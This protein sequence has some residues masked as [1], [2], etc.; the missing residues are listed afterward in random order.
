M[1]L[2]IPLDRTT[3]YVVFGIIIIG[4]LVID[5]GILNRDAKKVS[6]QSAL[7]QTIFWIAISVVFGGLIYVGGIGTERTLDFFSAYL[8]EKALSV[9]NIF[10]IILILRYFKVEDK[11]YHKILFWGILGALVFRAIFIFMGA[12]LIAQ[13]HWILYLFGGFLIYSGIK[14]FFQKEDDEFD[15]AES[16]VAKHARKWLPITKGNYNGKFILFRNGKVFFTPLFLVIVLI[17]TTD[18]IFA[19]DSIPAAFAITTDHFVVYTSNI[20][21]VMGLRALF[22]LLAGILDRFYLLQKGLSFVLVFIGGKMF[23]DLFDIAVP[24]YLSFVVISITLV[25]SILFS[26][27]MPKTEDKIVTNP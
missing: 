8:T 9:D 20:F 16:A 21:A 24:T 25:S 12:I 7:L 1:L 26:L 10:V 15:P 22:F 27:L 2:N 17:E 5:L 4:F 13:F 14:M 19:V 11:Y 3:L 18:L 6:T 23:L